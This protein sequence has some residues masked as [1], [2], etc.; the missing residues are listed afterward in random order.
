[1]PES[2]SNIVLD[3]DCNSITLV[4]H[5]IDIHI[6]KLDEIYKS[7]FKRVDERITRVT[8]HQ[9]D[10]SIA[11]AKRID[12][13]RSVDVAAIET[14]NN[15]ATEQAKVLANQV[16]ASAETLRTLVSGTATTVAAQL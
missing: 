15:R 16:A 1:M 4:K 10:L 9:K 12:A 11:E 5:L 6:S 14:A 2:C 3:K 8:D 7:E 13:I